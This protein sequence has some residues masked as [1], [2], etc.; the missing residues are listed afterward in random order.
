MKPFNGAFGAYQARAI[1]A[2]GIILQGSFEPSIEARSLSIA[3]VFERGVPI[4]IRFSDFTGLPDI[5]DTTGAA[6]PRGFAVKFLMPDGSSFDIVTQSFNGFPVPT[7]AT[8]PID[9]CRPKN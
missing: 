3:P 2:K 6:D 1:H 9:Q 5:P 8:L 4:T 7:S